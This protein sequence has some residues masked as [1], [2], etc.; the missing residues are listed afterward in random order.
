VANDGII[1]LERHR[2]LLRRLIVGIG[3]IAALGIVQYATKQLFVDRLQI[4]GLTDGTAEWSLGQ[5]GTAVRPSGLSTS[6]IEFGVV[7]AMALP[8][9]IVYAMKA[10]TNRWLY[11][12]ILCLTTFAI[13]LSI[14]R[15]ALLCAA[16][17]VVIMAAAWSARARLLGL[18]FAAAAAATIY[19]VSPGALGTITRLFTGA[20]E[21]PSVLSRTGSFD[22]AFE[23]IGTSPY[24]GRGFGT[25]LP[26]YWILDNG[27]LGL[28]IE[29]GLLGLLGLLFLIVTAAWAARQARAL[30]ATDFDRDIAQALVASVAAGA[31]ALAFFVGFAFPQSA[32]TFFLVLGMCGAMLRLTLAERNPYGQPRLDDESVLLAGLPAQ[33]RRGGAMS[34]DR[35]V[36]V[37]RG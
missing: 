37:G 19:V 6:P 4:P 21:D 10:R 14:S 26:K 2:V 32:G 20:S 18:A 1:S 27:Y 8:P 9:V 25:F 33:R 22:V 17:G 15:S 23:F 7:L 13:M 11:R 35:N 36:V 5:R 3:L 29:G 24:L 31:T 34:R 30:A 12:V 16:V 28:L